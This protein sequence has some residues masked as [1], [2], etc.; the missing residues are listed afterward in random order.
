MRA[1]GV[2][3]A[4][5]IVNNAFSL[6]AVGQIMEVDRLVFE[7]APE[8]LD[9]D[10][11]H[12]AAPAVHGDRHARIL[13]HAGEVEAGAL[14]ALVGVE[15]LRLAASGQRLSQGLD[16]EPGVH[17]V[18]QPPEHNVAFRQ[19]HDRDQVQKATLDGVSGYA[20]SIPSRDCNFLV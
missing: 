11:V 5:P 13:E 14:A 9:E 3:E 20:A 18:R 1:L 6:E 10:V 8:P 19:V 12:I 15:Y 7:A 2:V 17:G 16:A 4:D